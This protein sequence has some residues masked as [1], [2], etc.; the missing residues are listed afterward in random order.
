M[1][2]NLYSTEFMT[3]RECRLKKYIDLKESVLG[4]AIREGQFIVNE[5]DDLFRLANLA[6]ATLID[7][8]ETKVFNVYQVWTGK[9]ASSN[10]WTGKRSNP[11]NQRTDVEAILSSYEVGEDTVDSA[12][13]VT[14]LFGQYIA[15]VDSNCFTGE[16]FDQNA[17]LTV[18]DGKLKVA[19][20][21]DPVIAYVDQF[22]TAD[23]LLRF[24]RV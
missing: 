3:R 9:R 18:E 6:G 11:D 19:E 15:E 20:G 8:P 16:E 13:Q 2:L 12:G 22:P 4:G 5:G 17:P 7:S 21:G 10:V 23:G 14:G 1:S 24:R